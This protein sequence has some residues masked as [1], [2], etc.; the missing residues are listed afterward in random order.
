ML[1]NNICSKFID[2]YNIVIHYIVI[3]LSNFMQKEVHS[4][5]EFTSFFACSEPNLTCCV[6]PCVYKV[7]LNSFKKYEIL[8]LYH[9]L[10]KFYGQP[11]FI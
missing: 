2:V 6:V 1:V 9:F 8:V 11:Q 10:V 4:S 3:Y 7:I 5:K